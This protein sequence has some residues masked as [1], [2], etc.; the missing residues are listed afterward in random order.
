MSLAREEADLADYLPSVFPHPRTDL[1]SNP[2][3]LYILSNNLVEA[4]NGFDRMEVHKLL[5][6]GNKRR[7]FKMYGGKK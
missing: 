7:H 5:R 6:K 2:A 3:S 1:T 4:S